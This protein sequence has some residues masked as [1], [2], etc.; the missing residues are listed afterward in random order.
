MPPPDTTLIAGQTG[1]PPDSV[2]GMDSAQFMQYMGRYYDSVSYENTRHASGHRPTF[3]LSEGTMFL[4][5]VGILA[6]LYLLFVYFPGLMERSYA[7]AADKKVDEEIAAKKVKYDA[8]FRKYNPYYCSLPAEMQ[9]LFLRR[10]IR[11]VNEKEF[12]FHQLPEEEYMSVLVSGAAVQMT[13]GL[14]NYLLDYYPVIH[15]IRKEYVL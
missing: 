13:L 9:E 7:K 8:W 11:F 1:P 15:V 5:V 6:L 2:T 4:I 3:P 10:T 12:R 14:K